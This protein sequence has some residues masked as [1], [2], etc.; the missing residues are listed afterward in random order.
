MFWKWAG[1]GQGKEVETARLAI[2]RDD[3]TGKTFYEASIPW[4]D[5]G[6]SFD[7]AQ[8]GLTFSYTVLDNDGDGFRGWVEWTPGVCGTGRNSADFGRLLFK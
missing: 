3:A 5:L 6:I 2:K 4:K 8:K 1:G 7:K